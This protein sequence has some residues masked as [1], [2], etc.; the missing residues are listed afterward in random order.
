MSYWGGWRPHIDAALVVD[1]GRL[2]RWGALQDGARGTLIWRSN[3]DGESNSVGYMTA[4][5][6][7]SGTLTLAYSQSD[8]D[9]GERKQT[10]CRIRLSSLPLNY[11]GR[12]WYMHCPYTGRRALKLYK[13]SGIEQFCHRTA[14][15]PPP[16]YASQRLSGSDRV[17][18]QCWALRRKLGDTFSDLYG[19]PFK[20]KRMR[21]AT[22][23]RYAERDAELAAREDA[24]LCGM[25]MRMMA[26]TGV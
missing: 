8:R 3:H 19:E 4:I 10:E 5:Q 20:P 13:F 12:R 7:E 22:F 17:I 16:T 1:I 11:G 21:W 23:E 24:Y 15:R 25:L 9:T 18:A 14:I 2:I 26:K 6:G